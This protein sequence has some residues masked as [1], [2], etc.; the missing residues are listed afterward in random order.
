MKRI[1]SLM[2][3][4]I[5]V[6]CLAACSGQG[7]STAESGNADVTE[8]TAEKETEPGSE[9]DTDV[10]SE[11][12]GDYDLDNVDI[13]LTEM[14]STM[15]YS[16]VYD[17]LMSPDDYLGKTVRMSGNF[18]V[19]EYPERNYYACVIAD[20]TQ[21]C[22]QGLEFLLEGNFKYPDEYPQVGK[23]I[24]VV[25]VFDTYYEGQNRYVQLIHSKLS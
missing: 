22:S 15:T 3:A 8:K 17:M 20:A 13:D 18:A 5:C 12:A 24:T 23:N 9:T 21:C 7:G 6:V 11:T 14:N 19:Y 10:Q 2:L 4:L 16:Q 1:V 25:G